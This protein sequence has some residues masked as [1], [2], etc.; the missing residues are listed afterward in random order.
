MKT[1]GALMADVEAVLM[2]EALL[3][4]LTAL[5]GASVSRAPSLNLVKYVVVPFWLYSPARPLPEESTAVP[6]DPVSSSF[7]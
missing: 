3:L 5:S 7:Q 6:A 2:Q 4:S 1:C